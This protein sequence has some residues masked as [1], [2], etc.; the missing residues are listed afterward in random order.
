MPEPL[1]R[2]L[3]AV[4]DSVRHVALPT[5]FAVG[6]VNCY[7]LPERP[8]TVVDP[9]MMLPASL[10]LLEGL[11]ANEG[12]RPADVEAVVVTH[13][14][15]DHFGAAA[16]LAEAADAPIVT[17]RY[18]VRKICL[19]HERVEAFRVVLAQLGMPAEAVDVFPTF[20]ERVSMLVAPA[21]ADM[22]SVVEDGD[23][24]F[25]GGRNFEVH[26]T[27]GHA[28]SHVSLFDG[29]VL[30]SGDHLLPRISPNPFLEIAEGDVPDRRRSLVEYLDSLERFAM[31]D[32]ECVLPGHGE[33]FCDVPLWVRRVRRHHERRAGEVHGLLVRSPGATAYALTRAMFPRLDGFEIMLGISEIVG[34]LDLLFAQGAA[35]VQGH[36]PECW[37]AT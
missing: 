9:G 22:F 30:M 6:P 20:M 15:P 28:A 24:L 19:G 13:G 1:T 31:L 2:L 11:L 35:L 10:E 16:W 27:P 32:P 23:S 18:E 3:D 37:Y 26:V 29:D 4:P 12:L 17:G 36:E 34:H 14:H 5:P 21:R 25:A 7:L 8:V 33:P